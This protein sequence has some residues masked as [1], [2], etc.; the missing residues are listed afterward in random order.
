MCTNIRTIY[1]MHGHTYSTQLWKQKLIYL[2]LYSRI[3]YFL[4]SRYHAVYA[5]FIVHTYV[6]PHVLAGQKCTNNMS[7]CEVQ[8]SITAAG[9]EQPSGD[10][11]TSTS[12]SSWIHCNC[13]VGQLPLRTYNCSQLQLSVHAFHLMTLQEPPPCMLFQSTLICRKICR[14]LLCSQSINLKGLMIT[15]YHSYGKPLSLW[16]AAPETV[17][18]GGGA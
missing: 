4:T 15:S 18:W 5:C 14:L 7:N 16:G 10:S 11:G 6:C 12:I 17:G 8:W 13:T 2:H 1:W 3:A 9:R